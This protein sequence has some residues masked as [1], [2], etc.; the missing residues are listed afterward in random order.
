[1]IDLEAGSPRG[2]YMGGGIIISSTVHTASVLV[3]LI[4]SDIFLK[5]ICIKDP[6]ISLGGKDQNFYFSVN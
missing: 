3:Y 6:F 1:M 4:I 5:K 2:I